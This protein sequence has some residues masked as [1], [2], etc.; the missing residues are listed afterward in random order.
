MDA[1][2]DPANWVWQIVLLVVLVLLNAFF[3]MSEIAV[4]SLNDA[5]IRKMAEEAKIAASPPGFSVSQCP[6]EKGPV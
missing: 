6:A 3:A 4:V 2:P 1:D 5:K